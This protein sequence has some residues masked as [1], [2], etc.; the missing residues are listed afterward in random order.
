MTPK[1]NT[2]IYL[3][4]M[5]LLKNCI[6][7]LLLFSLANL[8]IIQA[9][10]TE[11]SCSSFGIT[12]DGLG[13]SYES[14]SLTSLELQLKS[15]S[16]ANGNYQVMVYD[17][18]FASHWSFI[19]T[20]DVFSVNGP[21]NT[22]NL[23]I[24]PF[25][26][27]NL[28]ESTA[29]L[30]NPTVGL[31]SETDDK[32][33]YLYAGTRITGG[34]ISDVL[35]KLGTYSI[36]QP[37]L[38]CP[39]PMSVS[40]DRV[41][42]GVT[43]RCYSY[44]GMGCLQTLADTTFETSG[45][46]SPDYGMWRWA[47]FK[48]DSDNDFSFTLP[49]IADSEGRIV[50]PNVKFG[51]SGNR[52]IRISASYLGYTTSILN[53]KLTGACVN[54]SVTVKDNCDVCLESPPTSNQLGSAGEFDVCNQVSSS[55]QTQCLDCKNKNGVWT[56]IGCITT[57]PEGILERFIALALGLGGGVALLTTIAG[58]FILT[59]SQGQPERANSAKEMIT[60]SVVG[61]LFIIFSVVIL[62]FIGVTILKIPGF[63]SS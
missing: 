23:Q 28:A 42:D 30:F 61:L 20:S 48:L 57:T 19:G 54:T 33:V 56:A 52:N 29:F 63:G 7:L 32:H 26:T 6:S 34:V 59:T 35:C 21:N 27:S 3:A 40:Q 50:F 22:V 2:K 25:N 1:E 46:Q 11:A 53:L 12:V 14:G 24:T 44:N 18:I 55:L 39:N 31:V 17:N 13:K 4:G 58:G 41:V 49:K 8:F 51:T 38:V 60:A 37:S 62:Q 15:G 43:K 45:I 47:Q 5:Q 36:K 9:H 10:A 16:I